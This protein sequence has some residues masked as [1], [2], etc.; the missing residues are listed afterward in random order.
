M[1][2]S[3]IGSSRPDWLPDIVSVNGPWGTVV[4]RLYEVF[5]QDFCEAGCSFQGR[6]VWW[7]RTKSDSPFEETFWHLITQFDYQQ[8][9][10]LFDPRRAERLPWCKPTITHCDEPVVSLWDYRES[11]GDVRT[12]L[13]LEN[14]DY[15]VILQKKQLNRDPVAFLVTAFYVEGDSTRKKLRR[16]RARR[17]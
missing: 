4:A 8:K 12:Y 7:D 16:K 17:V 11:N 9:E 10:R 15:I 1:T 14:W 5:R 3:S 13:W 2:A 6:P